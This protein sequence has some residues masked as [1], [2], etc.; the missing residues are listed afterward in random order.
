VSPQAT[1]GE[2]RAGFS[3]SGR[4]AATSPVPVEDQPN[5]RAKH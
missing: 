2:S 4:F 3:P 1:G 5:R